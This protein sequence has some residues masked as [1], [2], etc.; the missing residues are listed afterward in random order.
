[1]EE[2]CCKTMLYHL[3]LP[4][5]KVVKQQKPPK[6]RSPPV[7][8]SQSKIQQATSAVHARDTREDPI[9]NKQAAMMLE[10]R[11]KM[12]DQSELSF[13]Q[14]DFSQQ[15]GTSLQTPT[16][17]TRQDK[18]IIKLQQELKKARTRILALER[19]LHILTEKC[20]RIENPKD[21]FCIE[22]FKDS[23]DIQGRRAIVFSNL[24]FF[25]TYLGPASCDANAEEE[26]A[27]ANKLGD[28]PLH[29]APKTSCFWYWC[30]YGWACSSW[31]LPNMFHIH[32]SN[33]SRLFTT[34]INFMYLRLSGLPCWPS[35]AVIDKNMP[36]GFKQK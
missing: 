15:D 22:K 5:K 26:T 34:W 18:E 1:M 13:G 29:S 24:S 3:C 9:E 28:V 25:L 11:V 14:R 16:P 20:S 17:P 6:A 36:K 21:S 10:T 7:L 30:A 35:R 31:I 2:E 4:L 23:D 33:V 32:Q 19:E 8:P 12:R 27:P